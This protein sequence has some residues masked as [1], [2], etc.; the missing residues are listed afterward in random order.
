MIYV[1][2]SKN[3]TGE[4]L[5]QIV[6]KELQLDANTTVKAYSRQEFCKEFNVGDNNDNISMI[7]AVIDK[8][9]TDTVIMFDETPLE[10]R[11]VNQKPSYDWS[12]LK[13][14]RPSDVSVVVCLQPI[15]QFHTKLHKSRR[16]K[17]PK[18]ADNIMLKKQYRST[19]EVLRCVNKICGEGFAVEYSDI[20]AE[21]NHDIQGPKVTI[22]HK[23]EATDFSAFQRWLLFQLEN[24]KCHPRNG[25]IIYVS[26]TETLAR[27]SVKATKYSDILASLEEV[28][29]C[30]F[31]VVVA[32]FPNKD[33]SRL[34]EMSS[35]AQYKLFLVIHNDD[36]LCQSD[37]LSSFHFVTNEDMQVF[38][39]EPL[40]VST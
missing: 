30:E 28:Q 17:G 26:E 18:D 37:A 10:S 20:G 1:C 27:G 29:G 14:E 6:E 23:T 9:P 8:V 2:F 12:G 5:K 22:V 38:K 21:P 34:L 11:T 4:G 35:R 36:Q 3:N 31:P 39:K 19:K 24:L 25:K 32:F 13:N 40:R 15:G 33:Y 7:E 16:V